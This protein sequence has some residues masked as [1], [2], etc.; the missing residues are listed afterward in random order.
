VRG[1]VIPVSVR[2]TGPLDA[3]GSPFDWAMLSSSVEWEWSDCA[4]AILDDVNVAI[5]LRLL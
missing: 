4:A 1:R 2:W 3:V 5:D